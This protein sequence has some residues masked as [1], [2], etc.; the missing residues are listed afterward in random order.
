M[1]IELLTGRAAQ[2]R[3]ET[4]EFRAQWKRLYKQCP[5]RSVF[6]SDDF[7]VAWY[8]AYK[9]QFTP[10][11]VIG[12]DSTDALTGLFTLATDTSSGKLV[13]A[14]TSEAEYHA[15][16]T[17]PSDSNEFITSALD[18]LRT[19]FPNQMLTLLFVLPNVPLEW[20]AP[21][22]RWGQ[23]CALNTLPRGLMEIGDGKRFQDTLRKKKQSKIN[24]LKRLGHLHL[25]RIHDPEELGVIYDEMIVYQALRLHAIQN[26]SHLEHDP[27]R[28][29]F[30][31]NLLRAPRML[32]V[33]AL[34]VDDQLIS[35]QIHNYN[36][37]QARLGLITHSP[38]YAKY[39]PG[40]LHILMMGAELAQEEI[41][42]FDLTPG[43]HYKDRYATAH[44]EV[45]AVNIFFNRAHC[46]R[47]KIKRRLIEL[48]KSVLQ[49]FGITPEQTKDVFAQLRDW[50]Q[51]W[52]RMKPT[53]LLPAA[54]RYLKRSWWH[55]E[56]L[57]VYAYD[58]QHAHS[59]PE[60]QT[61]K[62]DYLPDVLA[63]Q[64]LEPRQ[65]PLN[66]F[67]KQA[68][69]RLEAGHHIYTQCNDGTLQQYAWLVEPPSQKTSTP[70]GLVLPPDAVL[71]TDFYTVSQ[72]PT[73]PEASLCQLL[74]E[75]ADLPNAQQAFICVAANN[76][77]L[78]RVL[79]TRG[80]TYQYS[81]FTKTRWGKTTTWSTAPAPVTI[82]QTAS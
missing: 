57:R 32:H 58:L 8:D 11:V 59:L 50:L 15:W 6:Q 68:L 19:Q 9:S 27:F 54:V 42:H 44:D 82:P 43:G 37:D 33:T 13:V 21:D 36:E 71:L 34:R 75:A 76:D 17:A 12:T 81:L 61:L 39:S 53:T 1:N 80:F 23:H 64:P 4:A 30:Y 73:L 2:Q 41:A 22:S 25:D 10:V 74:R 18:R 40:E 51:K 26:L 60:T 48:G 78:R 67:M 63:Y 7:V 69:E 52:R 70:P 79:E 14:G 77:R 35:A 24:R 46:T 45:F 5:W 65:L 28:K 31:M 16:L 3:I 55:T 66:Q 62:R 56:E 38:F 47:Y 29:T 72:G 49:R 20:T